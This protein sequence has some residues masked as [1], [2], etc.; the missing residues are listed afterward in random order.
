MIGLTPLQDLREFPLKTSPLRQLADVGIRAADR[1]GSIAGSVIERNVR[2]GVT[3]FRRSG[4]TVFVTSLINNLLGA[5]RLPFLD[6]IATGRFEA[7]RLRSHP[8]AAVPLF[9]YD[10][11][12]ADLNADIPAWPQATRAVSHARIAVRYRPVSVL[13]RRVQPVATLNIDVV[14]YPGEWLL[15]LPLLRRSFESWSRETLA[16]SERPPRAGLAA[17]WRDHL[18]TLS[19][20]APADDGVIRRAAE[21]YTAYLQACRRSSTSLSLLQPGRFLEP[22]ELAGAPLLT[23]CPLPP[24]RGTPRRGS[25]AAVMEERFEAYKRTVVRG[26]FREQFGRLDR[27]IVL[28]DV[29]GALNSGEAGLSDMQTALAATLEGFRHGRSNWL[30]R[31]FG[32]R[33]DRVL[34]AATKADHVPS[35]QHAALR[36]L[37]SSL[38]AETRNAIRFEGA[39][40]ETMA[41]ASVKSTETVLADHDGRKL[42]C[43]RGIPL[44]RTEPT[45]L[46]PGSV[47]SDRTELPAVADGRFGFLDFR[48]PAGLARDGRGLPNIRL[49][50]A[51]QFLIGD[52]L[53]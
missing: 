27:Q 5:G 10:R 20:D 25:V 15:D 44:G 6:A 13:R 38:V 16:L 30:A 42:A 37:L 34:F 36:G 1:A 35:G 23:F 11:H 8:D 39:A 21:L 2:L 19:P 53:A 45:V 29:L 33:I 40:I 46:F 24:G 51:L 4:K 47:P 48:P 31:M 43:V 52:Y 9:D 14:D 28:V 32:A 12:L 7:A 17:A 3:G 22:G 50:Q 41:I 49:D 18:A 26:F